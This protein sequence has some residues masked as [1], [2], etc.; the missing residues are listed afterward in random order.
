MVP[1]RSSEGMPGRER[2][3]VTVKDASLRR[4]KVAEKPFLKC[5]TQDGAGRYDA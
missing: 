2:S 5:C 1:E 3:E 4:R